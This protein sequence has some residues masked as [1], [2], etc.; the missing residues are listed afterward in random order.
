MDEIRAVHSS[1]YLD[2]IREHAVKENPYSYDRDTYL[3]E[4]SIPTAQLAA[5]GCLA[6]VDR[7][8]A[9]ELQYGF[10]LIR[11]P[12]HHAT[13]GRGMG[14]CLFNNVAVTAEYLRRQYGFHRILIVDFD[15][16]HANGTQEI[17][18]DTNEVMVL[19]IHQ[20]GLFPFSGDPEDVGSEKGLGYSVNIPVHAQ[21][22]DAEYT[23]LMG[24][25][26]QG[27]VEQYLPQ[28]ILVSA[29]Y[30]GHADDS[31]S[32]T[33]LTSQWYGVVTN[34]LRLH[35]RDVC[36]N[37]LLL[38]MEGGYN[39]VSLESSVLATI[40]ALVQKEIKQPGIL[41]VPRAD[42]LLDGHPIREFWA[43]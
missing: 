26:L 23:Y 40:A 3:M 20:K 22:G 15:I 33:L 25:L 27:I 42:R 14:F 10:A 11:P 21:F 7:I 30:D 19:S 16:H 8:L 37:R 1:F 18:Y 34:I 9:D 32:S 28:I 4:D 41:P 43:L 29:G 35:A 36:N 38:V 24:R 2:Q 31:I 13:A 17:F 6:L 5:G 12:G 39:P